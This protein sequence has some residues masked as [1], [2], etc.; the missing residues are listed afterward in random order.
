[1]F[2]KISWKT[3]V[4]LLVLGLLASATLAQK[5]PPRPR[6]QAA[7]AT[8]ATI[9]G[10]EA[11]FTTM[12]ALYA[13]GYEGDV[14]ADNWTAFRARI[15]ELTRKQ[16]GPAVDAVREFYNGHEFRD[17]GAMLSRFVW[18][19]LV[20]GPAP[21][22][23]PVMRRDEL[24]PEVLDLEGFSEILSAYYTE[25]KI[26][27]LW[28]DVQPVYLR[29]IERLHDPV[30][31]ILFVATT[32]LRELPD[33]AE[34]R[35]FSII[36]EPL[37]GRITNVRNF[38]DH[39]AIVLSGSEEIPLDVVRHAY[40]HFLLDP[41]PLKYSH[42]VVVKRPLFEVAAKAPRLAPD[43]KDDYFSWFA[44]CTVR[45]VELK[46]KRMSPGERESALK[47]D[48]DDG[49]VLVRPLFGGL[50]GFADAEPPMKQ[51][52]PDMVRGIDMKVEQ[53]RVAGIQFSSADA[54]PSPKELSREAVS[55]SRASAVTTVPN[56]QDAI[57][58]LTEGERR[59]A[60]RNPRAA[61]VSF[62]TVLAKYPDQVRAW[63][64]M[65]LVALLDHDG[66]KAKEVFGRLTRGE[67]AAV[68]DPLV[69]AWSHVYLARIY[70]DEGQLD[71]AKTEYQAVL[72]VQGA[73]TKAQQA[74]QKGLGD[75]DL[76][77]SSERP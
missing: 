32:Y 15:R 35:M 17:P 9:D 74:A 51:Y 10:S 40:L 6:P 36:V 58:A 57:A 50:T 71:R 3:C 59:I 13:S 24:P 30:S 16:Q 45:A 11:M 67:H 22:F 8:N 21:K 2:R 47:A 66:Q 14:S 43:L 68:E 26:G 63:Y 55:R 75:L 54:S 60:E 65:G 70:E 29:E 64:G 72:T 27:A 53:Q 18:F 7:P 46:L 37:V 69:M 42:V 34:P 38:G 20:S 48:D 12:C 49:L 39:Y 4:I 5:L 1:M 33:P 23:Q 19:G 28:K 61:E 76:R 41:L 44:E 25:Q 77:K 56:D 31:Q 73:P 62:K 52:F